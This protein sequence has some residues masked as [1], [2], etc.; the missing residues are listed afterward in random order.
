MKQSPEL[1]FERDE[2]KESEQSPVEPLIQDGSTMQL[3]DILKTDA[4]SFMIHRQTNF[5]HK[6]LTKSSA[7]SAVRYN[8]SVSSKNESTVKSTASRESIYTNAEQ[9]GAVDSEDE[10]SWS[11]VC[12]S[13]DSDSSPTATLTDV[14]VD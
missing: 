2:K 3:R 13:S 6:F 4:L 9:A 10:Q 1:V 7:T 12:W 14:N 11:T 5:P 8:E